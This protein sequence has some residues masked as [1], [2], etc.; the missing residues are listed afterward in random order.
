MILKR[1]MTGRLNLLAPAMAVAKELMSV[2]EFSSTSGELF[3]EETRTVINFKKALLLAAGAAVQK[4]QTKLRDEQEILMNLADMAIIIF[5]AESAL[6]R[7][8]KMNDQSIYADIVRCY[9]QDAADIINIAGKEAI[10]AFSEGDEQ[11]MLLLGM[12]RF[13]K[14]TPFNTKD[15]RRRIADKLIKDNKYSL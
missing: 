6:L 4:L 5:H 7:A 13:T 8:K 10:N 11:R 2:P 12:K 3:E 1:A 14:T 15:A 9:I